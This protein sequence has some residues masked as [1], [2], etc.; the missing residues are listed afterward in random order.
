MSTVHRDLRLRH[1]SQALT[2]CDLYG[3]A[4]ALNPGDGSFEAGLFGTAVAEGGIMGATTAMNAGFMNCAAKANKNDNDKYQSINQ[5]I[6][7]HTPTPTANQL[8]N[9]R[10]RSIMKQPREGKANNGW[11]LT[12]TRRTTGHT[13][14]LDRIVFPIE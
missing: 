12:G 2:L 14:A 1:K 11:L 6:P 7:T 3:R 10:G 13:Q 9:D 8:C 5:S 4:P